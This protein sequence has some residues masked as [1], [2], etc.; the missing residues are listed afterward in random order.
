MNRASSWS[1]NQSHTCTTNPSSSK[2]KPLFPVQ[3]V[4]HLLEER[5]RQ[6]RDCLFVVTGCRDARSPPL[7]F[8][9]ACQKVKHLGN[10]KTINHRDSFTSHHHVIK[11]LS[12]ITI[13]V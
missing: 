8:T 9:S 12:D 2:L 7:F 11:I 10:D 13:I 4:G 1:M 3:Y 5:E 6:G